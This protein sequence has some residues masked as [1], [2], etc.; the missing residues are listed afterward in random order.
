MDE[1]SVMAA[2]IERF[3]G[4]LGHDLRGCGPGIAERWDRLLAAGVEHPGA[5][6]ADWLEPSML[7]GPVAGL[8]ANSPDIGAL[9]HALARFHP[10]W[11]EDRITLEPHQA[12]DAG[13]G[14]RVGVDGSD[15]RPAHPE[16][17]RAFFAVLVRLVGR[18]VGA[19]TIV[20][21]QRRGS[22]AGEFLLFTR[23]QLATRLVNADPTVATL[24]TGV[25]E[26]E[27]AAR[28]T[29]LADLRLAVRSS[30]PVVPTLRQLADRTACSPRS[31]QLR[32]AEEGTTLR[33]LLD[34][35]RRAVGLGLLAAGSCPV[36]EAG[37]RA[38]FTSPE[39]FTRAVRRWTGMTPTEWRRL[40]PR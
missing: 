20:V 2:T 25:A 24:L 6:F 23:R 31:L 39:G 17:R 18:G 38:G 22:G 3:A 19:D 35:E 34:E 9:L 36:A 4:T 29:W 14:L 27:L 30:L 12:A 13:G 5:R 7:G 10:L 40:G 28:R 33:E 16:T 21:P 26:A 11:G 32:L 37:H 15:G 8:L 1:A